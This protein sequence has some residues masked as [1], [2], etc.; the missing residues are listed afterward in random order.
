MGVRNCVEVKRTSN[1]VLLP[2]A[3]VESIQC[4]SIYRTEL[5]VSA[6]QDWCRCW[7]FNFE[8]RCQVKFINVFPRRLARIKTPLLHRGVTGAK[9]KRYSSAV[10]TAAESLDS[11]GDGVWVSLCSPWKGRP[12]RSG[13]MKSKRRKSF[14]LSSHLKPKWIF[15]SVEF[16]RR[17]QSSKEEKM[18]SLFLERFL[19]EV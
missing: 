9:S 13:I 7:N 1:F 8:Y 12:T 15:I 16:L 18:A 6:S 10:H 11:Q 3:N 4:G 5:E 2:S 19:G 14:L 17:L